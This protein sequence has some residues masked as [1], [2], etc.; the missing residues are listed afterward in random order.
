MRETTWI[1]RTTAVMS[2]VTVLVVVVAEWRRSE[3]KVRVEAAR[4]PAV[5]ADPPVEILLGRGVATLGPVFD[6]AAPGADAKAAAERVRLAAHASAVRIEDGDVRVYFGEADRCHELRAAMVRA[7]GEPSSGR[8]WLGG[9]HRRATYLE[10][11]EQLG[12]D[13]C[14]LVFDRYLDAAEWVAALPIDAIRR[15]SSLHTPDDLIVEQLGANCYAS[16]WS[17]TGLG[18]TNERTEYTLYMVDERAV[19]IGVTARNASGFEQVRAAL[20]E[21][22][23]AAPKV[24]IE[25]DSG[26]VLRWERP[27]QV[28][29]QHLGSDFH[30]MIGEYPKQ[31]RSGAR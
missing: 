9:S 28:T 6:G 13:G 22:L 15:P 30:V 19:W 3:P 26:E 4:V 27:V 1:A 25:K 5:R 17:D 24:E 7:W 12:S 31:C 16:A 21:R 10:G 11:K 29:A 20:E 8:A 14:G 18:A 23:K 2:I